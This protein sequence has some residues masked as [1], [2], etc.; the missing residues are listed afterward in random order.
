MAA[1][2]RAQTVDRGPDKPEKGRIRA[3]NEA[4]LLRAAEDVFARVGFAGATLE[5]I[6][7]RA[8]L[9]KANLIYYFKSKRGLYRAVLDH[10]L[11]LWLSQTAV[12]IQTS[13]PRDAIEAYVRAKMAFSR[14]FPSASKVFATEIIAGAPTIHDFLNQDLRTL[15]DEKCQV[16]TRWMETGR[17]SRFDPRHF[18]FMVWATTQTYA[19]FTTQIDAVTGSQ[20]TTADRYSCATEEV[21]GFVL[22]GCGFSYPNCK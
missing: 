15:V 21:V 19:D 16:L 12:F 14:D 2:L 20:S 9:P 5:E 1:T 13:D 6:A 4:V 22:R 17:L 3:A 18:F 7:T 10:I 11:A 8:G